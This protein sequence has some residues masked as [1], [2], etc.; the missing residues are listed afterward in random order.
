MLP[1][2]VDSF[3]SPAQEDLS[4]QLYKKHVSP[5]NKGFFAVRARLYATIS[6][7]KNKRIDGGLV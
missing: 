2:C 5:V 7:R 6:A 4:R 3:P 1:V